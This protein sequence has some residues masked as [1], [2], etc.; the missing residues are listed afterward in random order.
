MC[1]SY[2][3]TYGKNARKT[4]ISTACCNKTHKPKKSKIPPKCSKKIL[5]NVLHIYLQTL[6]KNLAADINTMKNAK[7]N[8]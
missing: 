1:F 5:F 8:R 6:K 4:A 7:E 3:E 2:K